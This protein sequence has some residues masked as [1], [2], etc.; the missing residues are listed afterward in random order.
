[1]M[2]LEADPSPRAA[3]FSRHSDFNQNAVH[4]TTD[5][6]KATDNTNS[7]AGRS[8][9]SDPYD[10]MNLYRGFKTDGPVASLSPALDS[11]GKLN[12][13][14][15]YDH[16]QPKNAYEDHAVKNGESLW[17]IAA[18]SLRK[19]DSHGKFSADQVWQ[20]MHSIVE[21]NMTNHP[22]FKKNPFLIHPGDLLHVPNV[23]K[24][25]EGQSGHQA[26]PQPGHFP[27]HQ[28][29]YRP[30]HGQ[31]HLRHHGRYHG[32][33]HG[34]NGELGSNP[35]GAADASSAAGALPQGEAASNAPAGRA[36]PPRSDDGGRLVRA[37]GQLGHD[38]A[39][40]LGRALSG[41]A[42]IEASKLQ[43][44]GDC[45]HGP[46][47]TLEHFGIQISPMPATQQGRIL[48]NS[49]L[50]AR[51]DPSQVQPGDYGYRHWSAATIRK[52]GMGDL[53][54]SFIVTGG[55][56]N[57]LSAA[58]DHFFT[59]PPGGGYYAPGITFLR[60]NERFYQAYEHYLQTGERT[61]L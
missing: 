36:E 13:A 7:S 15:V 8:P 5:F 6:T 39:G 55:N 59:V 32:R 21:A 38:I 53:G 4:N 14:P 3:E 11:S 41:Q 26:E 47:K 27:E 28:A 60:P 54:D 35:S 58:N 22:E 18:D 46:R 61:K 43:T 23:D 50:F 24:P 20:R 2:S 56:K 10:I 34:Y 42:N 9:A 44:V 49:G 30:A 29:A 12:F 51:V 52:R 48:E 33:G 25:I 57:G 16:A 17:Q 37:I 40:G 45:A 19:N 1:M 31:G